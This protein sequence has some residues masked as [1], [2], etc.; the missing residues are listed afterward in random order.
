[1]EREFCVRFAAVFEIYTDSTENTDDLRNLRLKKLD[2]KNITKIFSVVK[3]IRNNIECLKSKVFLKRIMRDFGKSVLDSALDITNVLYDIY[4][5]DIIC[6]IEVNCEPYKLSDL[7]INGRDIIETMDMN[8]REN[9]KKIGVILSQ[10][11][12]Y[13]IE[14]PEKNR[15]GELLEFAGNYYDNSGSVYQLRHS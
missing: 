8:N 6:E 3:I 9:N 15:R 2:V 13:V 14:N 11:L 1:M 12:E 4:A 10:C 7:E 5:H